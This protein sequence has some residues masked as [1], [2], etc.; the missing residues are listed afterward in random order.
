M[1]IKS[2]FSG[3]WKSINTVWDKSTLTRVVVSFI[4]LCIVPA[5]V[6]SFAYVG[7]NPKLR[8]TSKSIKTKINKTLTTPKETWRTTVYVKWLDGNIQKLEVQNIKPLIGHDI[9]EIITEN[10][11]KLYFPT[12]SVVVLERKVKNG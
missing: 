10:G 1:K 5:V 4:V 11:D 2:F 9:Y 12:E 8:S 3:I 7:C 6:C